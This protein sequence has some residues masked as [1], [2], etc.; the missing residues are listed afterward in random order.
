MTPFF[1]KF[2][3]TNW[4]LFL[5]M[6]S[7]AVFGVIAINS[8]TYMRED[9][10]VAGF[11]R[12]QAIWAMAGTVAFFA[13]SLVDYRWVRWGS[14]LLY[15]TGLGLL[16]AT[17]FIG[18]KIDGSRRWI[19]LGPMNFQP[20]Q[21]ALLSTILV[22]ALVLSQLRQLHPFF[23]LVICGAVVAAP[24]LLI[25]IQPDLGS[26]IVWFPVVMV[27]L[28]AG[29]IPKRYLIAILAIV[30]AIVPI[31]LNFGLKPYQRDRITAFLNPEIDPQGISWAINQSLIAVGSGGWSGKGYK[32]PNTQVDLGFLPSTAVHNDYIFAVIAE[33]WGFIGGTMLIGAFALLLC[34]CL[35]IGMTSAD[36]LGLLISAGI[37]A[38]LF[39]HIFQNVG[40]TIAVLPI[41][42]LP[43]PLLSYSGSF[44]VVVMFAMGLVNSVWV[45]RHSTG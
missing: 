16:V 18:V 26:T 36:R 40:M 14:V 45:H 24:A 32:A 3:S 15:L 30:M 9:P 33:Q 10:F 4:L 37:A 34:T 17:M 1:R 28:F 35:F 41:T 43:L 22:I 8:A 42:G 2:I 44:V 20:S 5:L 13:A 38:L 39:A 12:R 29:G 7:L 6:A 27:M 11:Y 31:F 23:K 25:L 19:D 21:L